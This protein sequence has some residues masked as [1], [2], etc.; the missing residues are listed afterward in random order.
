M[1]FPLFLS[2]QWWTLSS[3]EETWAFF[4][5][6]GY[7]GWVVSVSFIGIIFGALCSNHFCGFLLVICG[8]Q[9]DICS[10]HQDAK[11]WKNLDSINWIFIL[12][13][14]LLVKDSC[15]WKL[16]LSNWNLILVVMNFLAL[17]FYSSAAII[18]VRYKCSVCIVVLIT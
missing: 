18:S 2:S 1:S 8:I 13:L 11:V 6:E 4:S 3:T 12:S 10:G 5:S 15:F 14:R 9:Y 7:R 17:I 16:K